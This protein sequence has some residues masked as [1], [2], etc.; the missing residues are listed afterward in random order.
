METS[1]K[2]GVSNA[3]SGAL[4]GA[5][6]NTTFDNVVSDVAVKVNRTAGN[7]AYIGGIAGKAQNCT[8]TQCVNTGNIQGYNYVGGITGQALQGTQIDRCYNDGNISGNQYTGGIAGQLS[9]TSTA[10]NGI[11]SITNSYNR[12]NIT[13]TGNYSGGLTAQLQANTNEYQKNAVKNSYST[14]TVSGTSYSGAAFGAINNANAVVENVYYL[15][16]TAALGIGDDKGE[17]EVISKTEAQ[18]KSKNMI[19]ELN[20]AQ[21]DKAFGE[22]CFDAND[23][24]PVLV[25]RL[26]GIVSQMIDDLGVITLES[27]NKIEAIE[28][29][30]DSLPD[31]EKAKVT[32]SDKIEKAKES[33][34]KMTAAFNAIEKLDE[35]VT[36]K[37]G[38]AI[39]E[40]SKLY[41]E[42]SDEEKEQITNGDKLIELVTNFNQINDTYNKIKAIGNVTVH[43]GDTVKAARE[44]YDALSKTQK[45]QIINY[46][47]LEIA[48]REYNEIVKVYDRIQKLDDLTEEET[49]KNENNI[50][51]ARKAYEALEVSQKKKIENL[52]V[53]AIAE[54][55]LSDLKKANTP[56]VVSGLKAKAS[57]YK[58]V[59]ISWKAA[60]NAK[61]YA[62]YRATSKNK[63]YKLLT[64]TTKRSVTDTSLAT[65]T[66]Y[67]Y[68]VKSY[69][70]VGSAKVYAAYSKTA[71]AKPVLSKPANIKAKV[72]KRSAVI[73]WTKVS[74]ATGYKVYRA[75]KSKGK[76]SVVKTI[77]KQSTVKYTNKKLKSKKTYYYKVRAYKKVN[78]KLVY[79][80]YSKIVKIKAK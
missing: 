56:A 19:D 11:S 50:K 33:L 35:K 38:E 20:G 2:S 61:G 25:C 4:C 72:G 62:V 69:G 71:C 51:S 48:E 70:K 67:Y 58:T 54:K 9:L 65:G 21:E 31:T 52:S 68:K 36:L 37:S 42:L 40:A 24:Y 45:K 32:N 15:E 5:A 75:T 73:K 26:G 23:G 28:A 1:H 66:T 14:G 79:G 17:H 78:G 55:D 22:D 41:N 60:K 49:I 30:Y 3:C 76:Y 27:G 43:S 80:S 47:E 77:A 7:W 74:G 29:A 39:N 18:L 63:T 34:E 53:L 10:A 57:N 12:G 59:K 16:G 6:D 13:A 46:A 64:Y 8:I 44:A